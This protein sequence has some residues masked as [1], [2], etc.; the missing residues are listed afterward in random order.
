LQPGR[1]TQNVLP[2]ANLVRTLLIKPG[3]IFCVFLQS[4]CRWCKAT[5]ANEIA[6]KTEAPMSPSDIG[7]VG[8]FFQ[9][10]FL[11]NLID[12]PHR[13][14]EP[15]AEY[16]TVMAKQKVRPTALQWFFRT[17]TYNLYAFTPEKPLS[18]VERNFYLAISRAFAS[19]S[20]LFLLQ[21]VQ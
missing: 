15:P 12:D 17:S 2:D 6:E 10:Q 20:T 21:D 18:L 11:K 8:V 13:C 7:L 4:L 5:G 3:D 9:S 16:Q 19:A 1:P 14:L